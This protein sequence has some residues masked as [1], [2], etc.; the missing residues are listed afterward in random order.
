LQILPPWL[1]RKIDSSVNRVRGGN[2][3]DLRLC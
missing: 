3:T 1:L 2:S